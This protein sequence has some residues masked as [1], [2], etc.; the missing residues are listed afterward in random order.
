M[1]NAM[2]LT[3][4]EVEACVQWI[5]RA[6]PRP[7][8]VLAHPRTKARLANLATIKILSA[9]LADERWVTLVYAPSSLAEEWRWH[10]CD[11]VTGDGRLASVARGTPEWSELMERGILPRPPPSEED[12]ARAYAET[13]R[14]GRIAGRDDWR[15]ADE[16]EAGGA[17]ASV[18][19]HDDLRDLAAT[20]INVFEAREGGGFVPIAPAS[21]FDALPEWLPMVVIAD[22]PVMSLSCRSVAMFIDDCALRGACLRFE[23][24]HMMSAVVPLSLY[25]HGAGQRFELHRDALLPLRAQVD[26]WLSGQVPR[27]S[28]LAWDTPLVAW[29]DGFDS[30]TPRSFLRG[31]EDRRLHPISFGVV[32]EALRDL[33]RAA[34]PL[35]AEPGELAE[36]AVLIRACDNAEAVLEACDDDGKEPPR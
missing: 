16:H 11:P 34:S 5:A 4:V 9:P 24:L 22:L 26:G 36:C 2:S 32:V 29:G 13:A 19:T 25:P 10:A 18:R 8:F 14:R 30:A 12:I 17:E 28:V 15:T 21:G 27:P 3:A 7:A 20:G 6:E 23:T 35:V 33:L 31:V 1:M